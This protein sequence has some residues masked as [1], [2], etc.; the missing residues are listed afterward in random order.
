MNRPAKFES[1]ATPWRRGWQRLTRIWR[2]DTVA[3]VDDELRFHFEQKVAEFEALGMSNAAAR[4]RADEEFGDVQVVRDSLTEI[5]GRVAKRRQRAEWWEG[6]LQDLRYVVRTLR[7]SPGFSLT[8]V[9][10]LALGLGANAA[11]FSLLD[12]LY[13]QTPPGVAK[14][15]EVRRVYYRRMNRGEL[16]TGQVFD[17]QGLERLRS[18][19][20]EGMQLAGYSTDTRTLGRTIDDPS[21]NVNFIDGNYFGV[22]R[23]QPALGRFFSAEEADVRRTEMVAVISNHLWQ[24]RY[25]RDPGVLGQIIEIGSHR[26]Q[27]I[28]VGPSQF[29]GLELNVADV[30]V[31]RSTQGTLFNRAADWYDN[32]TG[33]LDTRIIVREPNESIARLFENRATVS[34]RAAQKRDSTGTT[35]FGSII[36]ARG[37]TSLESE[38]KISTRLAGVAIVILLIACANVVNLL[39]ARAS[40][41]QREIALRLALGVSRARLMMQLL[42]ESSVLSI[43]AGVMSLVVAFVA[44]KLLRTLLLPDIHWGAGAIDQ[45]AVI[46]TAGIAL[47]TGFIAGLIPA[48]QASRPNLSGALKSSVRDGGNR[49][50]TLRSGLLV[51][52][53][54]LSVVLLAGAG[55]FVSSM[56]SVEAIDIGFDVDRLMFAGVGYD[57]E[58]GNK[59]AEIA[60]RIPE[61]AERVRRIPGVE[62][63]ALAASIPM[64]SI[65]FGELHLPDRDSTPRDPKGLIFRSNVAPDFFATVGMHALRGRLFEAADNAGGEP[66]IVVN[67]AFADLFWPGEDALQKCVITGP[68]GNPCRRVVGI[69]SHANYDGYIEEDAAKQYYLPLE[70]SEAG[71]RAATIAIRVAPGSAGAIA[72]KVKRELAD[73][74]G[75]WSRPNVKIMGEFL[76]PKLRPWRVGAQ[77]FTIAGFLALLVAAVGVYSSMAYTISQRTQEMGVRIALGASG[78]NVMRLVISDGVRVVAIG[79]TLGL[80]IALSLGSLVASLLYKTSPRDPLVL[81]ASIVTL[82][83]VTV[84]ACSIPAWRASRVDPLTALRAE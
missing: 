80:L 75:T 10:T 62:S 11:I 55:V 56:R 64:Y 63:V 28:G 40:V 73:E 43:A 8:V 24:T 78:A 21:V 25:N 45:R 83:I 36:E 12:R 41:R 18:V 16:Y 42:I 58:L 70:Q 48:I 65:G 79:V 60:Q 27:I 6:V 51:A 53:A 49:H 5:D 74:F 19:A 34:M 66:V 44:T 29:R 26:H 22:L 32:P 13:V 72:L 1:S 14:A 59:S 30:W 57:R 37:G 71:T 20:P 3:N 33:T 67:K 2:S 39:L 38:L 35:F 77:L 4:A 50:G 31:P 61:A 81:S 23:L 76:A 47:A 52:Q 46:F 15:E 69:V 9:I 7:R 84:V 17:R 82:L 68:R 54:A